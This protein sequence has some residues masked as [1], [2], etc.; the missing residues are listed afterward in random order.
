MAEPAVG[1]H[2]ECP[3]GK[4]ICRFIGA[5]KFSPGKWVGVELSEPNGKNNGTV[6]GIEY[7]QCKP[8]YGVFVRIS[9]IKVIEVRYSLR[10]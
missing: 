10:I 2:V 4:G 9:Q 7:F 1:D 8:N 6:Q 5:T 3:P